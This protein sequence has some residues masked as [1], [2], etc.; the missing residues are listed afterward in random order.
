MREVPQPGMSSGTPIVGLSNLSHLICLLAGFP[1]K[2]MRV[3][4]KRYRNRIVE[5]AGQFRRFKPD[6]RVSLAGRVL[7]GFEGEPAAAIEYGC[8]TTFAGWVKL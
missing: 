1:L 7:R 4:K 2:H 5:G 8:E 3:K 6:V